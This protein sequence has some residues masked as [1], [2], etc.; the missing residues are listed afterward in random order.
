[1][2]RRRDAVLAIVALPHAAVFADDHR[3]HGFTSLN[4]RDVEA[5]DPTRNGRQG[6]DGPQR[7]ERVV[8]RQT[9]IDEP[10]LI[11]DPG[12]AVGQLDQS[13]LLAALGH[14]HLHAAARPF[15]QPRLEQL[16][17]FRRA[18]QMHFRRRRPI[19]VELL[20][21]RLENFRGG[22]R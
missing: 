7:L 14:E 1:M 6:E 21:R 12:V 2:V 22:A 3:G 8:L 16:A 11:G 10:R 4:G 15:R 9:G 5:F 19:F 17:V 20:H 18:G 13:A